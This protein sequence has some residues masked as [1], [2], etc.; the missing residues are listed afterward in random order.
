M[1]DETWG[2]ARLIAVDPGPAPVEMEADD[3]RSV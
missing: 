3:G 1:P 2:A